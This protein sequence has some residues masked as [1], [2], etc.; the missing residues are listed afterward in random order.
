[1]FGDFVADLCQLFLAW[2]CNGL[3]SKLCDEVFW[4][5]VDFFSKCNA[6]VLRAT[7]CITGSK[8]EILM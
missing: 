8:L 1:M 3:F 6:A 4:R 7:R 5:S 2:I